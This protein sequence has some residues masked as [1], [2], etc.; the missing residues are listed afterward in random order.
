MGLPP[1]RGDFTALPSVGLFL[2]PCLRPSRRAIPGLGACFTVRVV[3]DRYNVISQ[4]KSKHDSMVTRV[5]SSFPFLWALARPFRWNPEISI[6][7]V[8][9]VVT[10][11]SGIGVCW[12]FE[13]FLA[14]IQGFSCIRATKRPDLSDVASFARHMHMFLLRVESWWNLFV[15]WNEYYENM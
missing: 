14:S 13:V 15:S 8:L 12:R 6:Y 1:C 3:S 4:N 10:R 9:F 5:F 7:R 2:L 11:R